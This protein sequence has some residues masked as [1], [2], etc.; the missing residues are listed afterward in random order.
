[1]NGI[2]EAISSVKLQKMISESNGIC[3]A[4]EIRREMIK[5]LM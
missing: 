4:D 3:D 1:M 2:K 5:W